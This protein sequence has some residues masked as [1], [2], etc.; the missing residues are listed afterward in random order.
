MND[1]ATIIALV[2]ITLIS[3]ATSAEALLRLRGPS[4]TA[5]ASAWPVVGITV[6]ILGSTA[7]FCYR[8][9]VVNEDYALLQAHVDGLLLVAALLGAMVL[10]LRTRRELRGLAAFMLPVQT[11]ILL[12]AI[13]AASFTFELFAVATPVK[14]LHRVGVYLG[15]LCV[16]V[17]AAAGGLYLLTQ[18]QL[19][20][21]RGADPGQPGN[22]GGNLET[23]ERLIIRTATLGFALLTVGLIT[24]AVIVAASETTRLGAG[25]WYSPKV[26]FALAAWLMY[27]IVM[28]VR[29]TTSF[30]GARAAWLAIIG[31][32]LMLGVF[33]I[34][35]ATPGQSKTNTNIHHAPNHL[36]DV[37]DR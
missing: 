19:R 10:V 1:P 26:L 22:P 9:L 32:A 35:S 5:R 18:R 8:W 7:L 33:G 17:A 14:T 20:N 16:A 4:N 6:A 23:V 37:E 31:L 30:R 29:H 3:L 36:P 2:V 27:A 15:T 24:G 12:W 34:M 25:W 11:L 21:K 28:C 13:C